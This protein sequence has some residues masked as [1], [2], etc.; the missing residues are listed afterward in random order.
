MKGIPGRLIAVLFVLMATEQPQLQAASPARCAGYGALQSFAVTDWESGLDGW[1][2]GTHDIANSGTFA[3]PDW[4]TAS[5]LPEQ[6]PGA[7]AFVQNILNDDCEGNDQSGALTLD[8]PSITIPPGIPVPRVSIDHWFD[9][10]HLWDG[11]NLKMS[12]NGGQFFRIEASAIEVRPYTA[13]LKELLDLNS[14]PLEGEPA[15][16]GPD[17]DGA[18]PAWGQSHI[19]LLGLAQPG[20]SVVLRLDFGID[21]CFGE[22]GWYVDEVEFYYCEAELAPSDCGNSVLDAGE[23]CD[24]GNNFVGDGCSNVCQ[25]EPGWSCSDP[26]PGADIND[27]GFEAGPPNNDWIQSSSTASMLI[28]NLEDCGNGLG[29]GPA[30]GDYWAWLGGATEPEVATLSQTVTIPDTAANLVFNFEVPQCSVPE[31]TFEVKVDGV[32]E[33]FIDGADS[34][35]NKVGYQQE[36]IDI[37]SYADGSPHTIAFHAEVTGANGDVSNFFIDNVQIPPRPGSCI[38]PDGV[39]F[40][41]GFEP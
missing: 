24:D 3:T 37:S 19:N 10:E 35:C 18:A 9:V 15:F 5:G 11:G 12:V 33:F 39:I 17:P 29:S 14:N 7:A 8:S 28:C 34:R 6:R 21:A 1:T 36:T 31:D 20:D 2:P 27:P 23:T 32:T 38:L 30:E 26:L 40:A 4:A 41:N 13:V 22:T 16:T 25:V